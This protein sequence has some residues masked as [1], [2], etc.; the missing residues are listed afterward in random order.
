MIR[1]PAV[2]PTSAAALRLVR[3]PL[4]GAGPLA[5]APAAP[6]GPPGTAGYTRP[7]SAQLREE[8]SAGFEPALRAFRRPPPRRSGA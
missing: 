8:R 6:G 7:C 1:A 4:A 5:V 2:R 3:R